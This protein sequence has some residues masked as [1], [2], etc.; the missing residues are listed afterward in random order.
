[1]EE[2]YPA[3][4]SGVAERVR[5]NLLIGCAVTLV[6]IFGDVELS[7]DSTVLG[8]K[9]VGLNLGV[10]YSILLI[11]L[12]YQLVHFIWHVWDEFAYW[13]VRL[14]GSKVVYQTT[15]RFAGEETDAPSDPKQSS[16]Y[17]WWLEKSENLAD[18]QELMGEL[19]EQVSQGG[20]SSEEKLNYAKVQ[21]G[22]NELKKA[23]EEIKP[24]MESKRVEESL[25]SFEKWY[26]LMVLSQSLRWFFL[27]AGLPIVLGFISVSFL[28]YS[29]ICASPAA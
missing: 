10:F 3:E 25:W 16:L 7:P 5:R 2:P 18:L 20:S 9:F 19:Q 12:S 28:S 14:T 11:F 23:V 29:L 27:E 15:M 21:T 24:I 4:F 6:P 8:L 22:L 13:R 17:S 26:G 1:M